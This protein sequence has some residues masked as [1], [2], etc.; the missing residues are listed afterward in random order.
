MPAQ[1]L[2]PFYL[3]ILLTL[4]RVYEKTNVSLMIK[5]PKHVIE[6][7]NDFYFLIRRSHCCFYLIQSI[8][9]IISENKS[10]EVKCSKGWIVK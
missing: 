6:C 3:K 1:E 5:N 10:N 9:Y 7:D 8:V 4:N 2:K